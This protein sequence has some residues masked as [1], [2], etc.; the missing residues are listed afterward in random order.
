M[1]TFIIL[2]PVTDSVDEPRKA[3]EMI[4]NTRDFDRL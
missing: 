3:C 4:E 1:K 2:I